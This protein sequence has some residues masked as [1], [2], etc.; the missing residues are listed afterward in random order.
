MFLAKSLKKKQDKRS[1]VYLYIFR[2]K[3]DIE[4]E[5]E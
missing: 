5:T 3:H 2:T 4:K 1:P